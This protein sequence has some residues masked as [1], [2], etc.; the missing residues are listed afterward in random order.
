ME[1]RCHFSHIMWRS[2]LSD[3]VSKTL[4]TEWSRPWHGALHSLSFLRTTSASRT[5]SNQLPKL[6]KYKIRRFKKIYTLIMT[7]TATKKLILNWKNKHWI[8]NIICKKLDHPSFTI[9]YVY[10]L[11]YGVRGGTVV[12][13][14]CYRL[15]GRIVLAWGSAVVQW[16]RC[17]AT[18]WKVVLYWL[19][20]PRWYSG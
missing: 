14:L 13:V 9:W 16:L 20:G 17:C 11:W 5:S 10:C 4:A 7:A 2:V 18:D 15:E 19:G 1:E 6:E 3:D 12:K 8:S